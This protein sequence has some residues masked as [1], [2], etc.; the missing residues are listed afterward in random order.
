M[1]NN[2]LNCDL[3]VDVD[4]NVIKQDY[5]GNI[6]RIY[7]VSEHK[8]PSDNSTNKSSSLENESFFKRHSGKLG[9]LFVLGVGAMGG[10]YIT[11]NRDSLPN[12][13]DNAINYS[14]PLLPY[15]AVSFVS[16][17]VGAKLGMAFMSKHYL[18]KKKLGNAENIE[19]YNE[20]DIR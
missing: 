11:E 16:A 19:K 15:A 5:A 7:L 10:M 6:E 8:E 2:D 9:L 4:G 1:G 17:I 14:R 20:D 13:L 12:C 3:F 18:S